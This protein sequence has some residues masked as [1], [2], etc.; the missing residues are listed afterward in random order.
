M[1]FSESPRHLPYNDCRNRR[2]QSKIYP[3]QTE[4]HRRWTSRTRR[5]EKSNGDFPEQDWGIFDRSRY[6]SWA[7]KTIA[8]KYH[9]WSWR[10]QYRINSLW[11]EILPEERQTI[12]DA[13]GRDI[14]HLIPSL[15]H[16]NKA[17]FHA[18]LHKFD[19]KMQKEPSDWFD[20]WLNGWL[21]W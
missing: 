7:G 16:S 17:N 6:C 9:P 15:I 1:G 19:T 12:D 21:R 3:Q 18:G 13:H 14:F 5:Q 4:E 20:R 11:L 2:D 10:Y 8:D